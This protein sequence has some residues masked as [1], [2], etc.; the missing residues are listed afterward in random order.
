MKSL[1]FFERRITLQYNARFGATAAVTPLKATCE[2]ERKYPAECLVKA[3]ADAKP[4]AV[5]CKRRKRGG[6]I[7]KALQQR[8]ARQDL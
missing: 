5:V 8:T 1:C 6:E 4:P 3:A 7:R 2:Y